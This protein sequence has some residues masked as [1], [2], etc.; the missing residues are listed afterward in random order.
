[1]AAAPDYI[2]TTDFSD[3]ELNNAGGRSTVRTANLD[4]ELANVSTAHNA[5][6]ANVQLNQRDDGEIR[7]QRVKL[8]TLAPEVA[9]LVTLLS[10]TL[11]GAWVTATAYAIKD[12]VTQGGNTYACVTA[13]TSGVFAT[14]LAAVRWILIQLGAATAA[15]GV[16]FS[17]TGTIAATNVQSAIDESDTEVRA[18]IAAEVSARAQITTDLLD[19]SSTSKGTGMIAWL[20]NATGAVVTT[21]YRLLNWRSYNVMEFMTDAQRADVEAGTLTLDVSGAINAA[22]TAAGNGGAI[23]LPNFPMLC[24]SPI[25][26]ENKRGL[27]IRGR[28]GQ[29]GFGGSRLVGKHT[30]KAAL[31][32]VGSLY[33]RLEGFTIEGDSSSRPKGGLLFG[34]SSS[35]S[36]GNHSCTDVNV[37]GYFQEIGVAIIASEENSFE[38]CYFVPNAAR[39]A[40]VLISPAD[41]QTLNGAAVTFG[42]LTA[43][44][45]E[46]NNFKGGAIGNGDNTAG[47]TALYIDCNAATGHHNFKGVFITKN[48]GDSFV[49][50]RL[51]AI[52]GAGTEFPIGFDNVI[53]ESGASDPT[54]G[55][56][57]IAGGTYIM[58]GF[59][60]E[61]VRWQTPSTN[62]I[63]CDGGGSVYMIG[64]KITHP[65]KA[66][67]R[68]ATVLHR[69][70]GGELSLLAESAVTI[71][72]LVASKLICN[73]VPTI[74]INTSNEVKNLSGTVFEIPPITKALVQKRTAPTYG[75]NVV[76][77]A[78]LGNQF[79]VSVSN[80][81]AFQVNS[82]TNSVDGQRITIKLQNNSGG[83]MGAVTW[84][85]SY[86]LAAWTSPATG[87][88]RSID[89]RFN[90]SNWV[91]ITRT[92]VDVPN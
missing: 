1:M 75:A 72:Q 85:A 69:V 30:G 52:D 45:M 43:S 25:L 29:Y 51:G 59:R 6:N 53:G 14:D 33:S 91:E 3:D 65:Y 9:K 44:S 21:L 2:P 28:K 20:R 64:P 12:V 79:D 71:N 22:I 50:I 68:K 82:P 66:A 39:V 88:S 48:G 10:G 61:N 90:G 76:I 92:T 47:T 15:S 11:R 46:C 5:L 77:D 35:A 24:T 63:L 58:S 23:E 55:I 57:F 89:F 17:P 41:G 80:G 83:A 87:F 36:A 49:T 26:A 81:T 86:K 7:D 78:S 38:N 60:A 73:P 27:T 67:N 31:S 13:H 40:G 34:R 8:H 16:P 18:L 19:G 54:N 62:N 4:A 84:G 37:Q 56:H 42:G 74:T 32:M 70:D